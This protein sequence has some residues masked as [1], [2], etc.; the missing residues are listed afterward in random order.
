MRAIS[1]ALASAAKAR[2]VPRKMLRGNW[3][4]SENQGQ[5]LGPGLRETVERPAGG[6]LVDAGVAPR[7]FP[8]RTP[9][10]NGTRPASARTRRRGSVVSN[11]NVRMSS[12]TGCMGGNRQDVGRAGELSTAAEPRV[13]GRR[14]YG[15]YTD[16]LTSD[17]LARIG[18]RNVVAPGR[19]CISRSARRGRRRCLS[20]VDHARTCAIAVR[21]NSGGWGVRLECKRVFDGSRESGH[22]LTSAGI[23]RRRHLPASWPDSFR[24]STSCRIA[25]RAGR[26]TGRRPDVD[27]RNKSG[28]DDGAWS[29]QRKSKLDSN[30]LV[31]GMTEEL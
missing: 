12:E 16:Y 29:A 18:N 23:A 27:A 21:F 14:D 8:G 26:G 28:H 2:G 11:Q 13:Q 10:S 7:R 19:T 22:G 20:P 30:G 24:P 5:T 1:R 9:A 17:R 15:A 4:E 3:V 31:P 6:A 25:V